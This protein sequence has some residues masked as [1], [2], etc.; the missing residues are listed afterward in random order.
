M[1]EY[2]SNSVFGLQ[3]N[4]YQEFIEKIATPIIKSII[5]TDDFEIVGSENHLSSLDFKNAKNPIASHIYKNFLSDIFKDKQSNK[6]YFKKK[7]CIT[8]D[9]RLCNEVCPNTGRKIT[10]IKIGGVEL[11]YF[12]YFDIGEFFDF[13]YNNSDKTETMVQNSS[14]K[15]SNLIS[16]NLDKKQI[17]AETDNSVKA[18]DLKDLDKLLKPTNLHQQQNQKYENIHFT[19]NQNHKV[20]TKIGYIH[21]NNEGFSYLRTSIDREGIFRIS[22]RRFPEIQNFSIGTVIKAEC[23]VDE[24]ERVQKVRSY[25][26]CSNDEL[27]ISFKEFV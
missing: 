12:I 27:D 17:L 4:L 8:L 5:K 15:N 25:Y 3:G 21:N 6:V 7:V 20:M 10:T 9:K 24:N 1:V 2:F 16:N 22:H 26:Q 19:N 11:V 18:N 14:N 23:E 13:V